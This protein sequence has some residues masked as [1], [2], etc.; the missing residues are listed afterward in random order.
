MPK[1][2]ECTQNWGHLVYTWGGQRIRA[3]SRVT[4]KIKGVETH[5][6]ARFVLKT[7]VGDMGQTYTANTQILALYWPELGIWVPVD[8]EKLL[9]KV[10]DAAVTYV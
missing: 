7:V 5:F 9:R 8:D 3:I 10:V 2:L 1:K 4:V 6:A